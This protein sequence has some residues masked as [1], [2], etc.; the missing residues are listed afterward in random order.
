MTFQQASDKVRQLNLQIN[1]QLRRAGILNHKGQNV[2]KLSDQPDSEWKTWMY[3][4]IS[5]RDYLIKEYNI[6]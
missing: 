1:S 3:D 6:N 4:L 5:V 2:K